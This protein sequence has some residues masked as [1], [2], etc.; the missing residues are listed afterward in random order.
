MPQTTQNPVEPTIVYGSGR[1][2]DAAIPRPGLKLRK[3]H[4]GIVVTDPQN[5]FLSPQGVAWGVVGQNVTENRAVKNIGQ[6]F[7]TAKELNIPLF[8]SPHYYF[9]HDHS[10]EFE[11]ALERLMHEINMFDRPGAARHQRLR[12]FGSRLAG[13]VQAVHQRWPDHRVQPT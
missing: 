11:G 13:A 4:V 12:R 9:P 3:G 10:W 7:V 5:D 6:L 1:K 2:P 8:I